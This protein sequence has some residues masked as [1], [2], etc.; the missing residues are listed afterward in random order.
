LLAC[1]Q[2]ALLSSKKKFKD[3][4][5]LHDVA[6][7]QEKLKDEYHCLQG[8]LLSLEKNFLGHHCL[9]GGIAFIPENIKDITPCNGGI[10]S[11]HNKNSMAS[12]LAMQV[13]KPY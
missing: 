5:P 13:E 8:G 9:K 3:I 6:I 4:H 7:F 11:I 10:T 1:L 12:L 2:W